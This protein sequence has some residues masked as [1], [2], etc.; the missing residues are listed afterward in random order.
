MRS[1]DAS[2]HAHTPP[3]QALKFG[4]GAV[5]KSRTPVWWPELVRDAMSGGMSAAFSTTLL[6]P[7]DTLKTRWQ[8]GQP[9]PSL[10]QVYSGYTPAV[11]YSALG[12]SLWVCSRNALERAIPDHP[13]GTAAQHWK[14]FACG[15]IAGVCVQ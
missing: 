4:S 8:L 6:F 7:L 12:M 15:A 9:T 2:P 1:T 5:I 10:R 13:P 11:L 3:A 14:H